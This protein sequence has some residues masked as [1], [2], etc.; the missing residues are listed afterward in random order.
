MANQETAKTVPLA[1]VPRGQDMPLSFAQQRLWF[2]AR[3]DPNSHSYNVPMFSKLVGRLD[4]GVLERCLQE[5]VA[6]H[7]VLRTHFPLV[8]GQPVQ[9]IAETLSLPLQ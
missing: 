7:E 2:E 5:L 8:S 4:I 6:R 3:L 1:P 9:R